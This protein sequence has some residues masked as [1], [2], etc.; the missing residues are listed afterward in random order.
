MAS[1]DVTE[2]A[3]N[4]GVPPTPA[5]LDAM[6]E[7]VLV[8]SKG[9]V[10]LDAVPGVLSASG[11]YVD[12]FDIAPLVHL[13]PT[14]NAIRQREES[15]GGGVSFI[16]SSLEVID[17]MK[18]GGIDPF[19]KPTNPSDGGSSESGSLVPT[20]HRRYAVV[21]SYMIKSAKNLVQHREWFYVGEAKKLLAG[22]S[23][24][25]GKKRARSPSP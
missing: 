16:P 24:R 3:M 5:Q 1:S 12:A 11:Y 21:T 7:K 17:H 25:E 13:V 8:R 15:A 18:A 23:G 4:A 10:V 19:L 22:P 6:R 14:L 20:P 2:P 9:Y